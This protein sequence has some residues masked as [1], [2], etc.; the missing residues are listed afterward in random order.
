MGRHPPQYLLVVDGVNCQGGENRVLSHV[1][2][3]VLLLNVPEHTLALL[4][5]SLAP[6]EAKL[7]RS[8]KHG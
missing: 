2:F 6:V 5:V 7:S 8:R 1:L 4:E 3:P